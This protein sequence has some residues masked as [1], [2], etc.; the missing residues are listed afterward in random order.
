MVNEEALSSFVKEGFE[1][2]LLDKERAQRVSVLSTKNNGAVDCGTFSAACM[3]KWM[4]F[5]KQN[6][7]CEH[8]HVIDEYSYAGLRNAATEHANFEKIGAHGLLW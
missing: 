6:T 4:I 1:S 5:S 3:V 2:A 8:R 7:N